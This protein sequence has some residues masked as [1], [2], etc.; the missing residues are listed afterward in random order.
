V[1]D[2]V[3]VEGDPDEVTGPL[4]AV[5]GGSDV[6][7]LDHVVQR[8]VRVV[9]GGRRRKASA[10]WDGDSVL[11]EG[12]SPR[13]AVR[14]QEIERTAV[15]VLI[16]AAPPLGRLEQIGAH[17]VLRSSTP[18][19]RTPHAGSVRSGWNVLAT[20]RKYAAAPPRARQRRSPV[21]LRGARWGMPA[22]FCRPASR[23]GSVDRLRSRQA[24]PPDQRL[25]RHVTETPVEEIDPHLGRSFAACAR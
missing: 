17:E 21:P 8:R 18:L 5:L 1:A 11:D 15:V 14:R 10:A 24:A 4:E 20:S 16:P 3:A 13:D 19:L 22:G 7:G 9:E 23:S 6:A 25:M 12:G 2:A